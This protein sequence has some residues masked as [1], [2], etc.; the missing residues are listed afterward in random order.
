MTGAT[1]HICVDLEGR[2]A[3]IPD[4]VMARLQAGMEKLAESQ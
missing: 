4:T 2:M 1:D 3:R